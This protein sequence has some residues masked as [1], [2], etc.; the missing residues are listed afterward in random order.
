M[1]VKQ[2]LLPVI[3]LVGFGLL[4][5]P[6]VEAG[7]FDRI[8]NG[9][10]K[11]GQ[12]IDRNIENSGN[13][14]YRS[15]PIP[16]AQPY[17]PATA[18][19]VAVPQR[20]QPP[21][22]QYRRTL[23]PSRDYV[24]PT[25]APSTAAPSPTPA[26]SP[27][28]SQNQSATEPRAQTAQS[29]VPERETRRT[30]RSADERQAA[31]TEAMKRL[32]DEPDSGLGSPVTAG[33]ISSFPDPVASLGGGAEF[34]GADGGRSEELAVEPDG[35]SDAES[36]NGSL[37]KQLPLAIAVPGKKGVV[38]SPFEHGKVVNVEGIVSGS[39]AKDP[40]TGTLFRVP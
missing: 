29:S 17:R 3:A 30:P 15:R 22:P 8:K 27:A 26:Q 13:D 14:G 37:G 31:V 12:G 11:A 19:P 40:Y 39:V 1:C 33:S 7:L 6:P 38:Y 16:K 32:L 25:S 10:K 36:L 28:S 24:G 18:P 23:V 21:P 4:S 34:S 9:I 5:P 2:K 20:T 35:W